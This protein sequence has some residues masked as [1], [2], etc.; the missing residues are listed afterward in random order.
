MP[1]LTELVIEQ[2]CPTEIDYRAK[3]YVTILTGPHIE[4]HINEGCTL[5]DLL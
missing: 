2:P 3:N 1:A 5:N 4:W